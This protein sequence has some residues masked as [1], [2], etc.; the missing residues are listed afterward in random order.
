MDELDEIVCDGLRIDD[1]MSY[2]R[3]ICISLGLFFDNSNAITM[4]GER[5]GTIT[6]GASG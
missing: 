4:N 2:E 1:E 6:P 5:R 3:G